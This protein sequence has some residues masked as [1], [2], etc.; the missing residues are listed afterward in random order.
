MWN[1][2]KRLLDGG[3]KRPP[4]YAGK[5]YVLREGRSVEADAAFMAWTDGDLNRM[6]EALSV[7]TNPIDRHFLLMGIVNETYRRRQDEEMAAR[8]AEVSE[9]H[10]REFAQIAPGLRRDMGGSLPRVTTFQHFA[11]LLT[12]R[13]EF[14]RA[15][16]VCEQ[17]IEFGLNDNTKSGFEGRIARIRKKQVKVS[18]VEESQLPQRGSGSDVSYKQLPAPFA[19]AHFDEHG[20]RCEPRRKSLETDV[21][22]EGS[23]MFDGDQAGA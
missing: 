9:L 6:L 10:L 15:V 18:S 16:A 17:A 11:T 19:E 4:S 12:E 5:S 2:V 13:G 20:S 21:R 3:S 8:C 14:D 7:P 1:W 23:G 22:P